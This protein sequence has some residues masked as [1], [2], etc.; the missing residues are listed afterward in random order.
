M[1]GLGE[2]GGRIGNRMEHL[3]GR[4]SA[5]VQATACATFVDEWVRAG[6]RHAVV[7]PGSRS[8]PLALALAADDRVTLEVFHDERSAAFAALG[9]GLATGV[10][11]VLV[12]TSGTAATHLHAAVVEADLSA[13]PML[14][15]TADR[16][17][18]L[19][20][21]GAPQ[22]IDQTHLYGRSVRWF[23]DPG[24]PEA[25]T[26]ATWR[27]VAAR[28]VVEATGA[29][30]GPVQ[31]NLPFR[32]PLVGV[33]AELP[34]G[35][36]GGAPWHRRVAARSLARLGD[37]LVTGLDAPR[38]VVVA[39][40]GCGDPAAVAALAEATGWPVIA[41]PRA[42]LDDSAEHVVA[43]ADAILRHAGFAADHRPDVVV[44]LG[45]PPAS[46]VLAQ[47]LAAS[48]AHQVLVSA[49]GAWHDPDRTAAVVL[50]ADPTEV[51]VQL[52]A[53]LR[54]A[55]GTP[56][57]A[58]WARAEAVA[59][60]AIAV[61]LE[62]SA[63]P[64]AALTEP[65]VA[66]RVV[67][68]VPAGGH[69]VVASSMPVR[70]VEWFGSRRPGR[71]VHANR[72]ANGIDGVVATGIGVALA[73]AAPTVVLVGDVAFAHDQS[74][75]TAL[76]RRGLALVVVVVD[77]GGGGIFSF[78]AQH[79]LVATDRFEQLFGTPHGTDVTTLAHA[80][81]LVVVT[82]DDPAALAGALDAAL[83]LAGRG[84]QAVVVHLTTVGRDANVAAHRRITDAV[85]AALGT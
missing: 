9:V 2:H 73:T 48:G 53:R 7:A 17:A 51:C 63:A 34:R 69:L 4:P 49:T 56:W 6:V 60:Q 45:E 33:C 5:D 83:D 70:D 16:P 29:R 12:C 82:C 36:P 44:R 1:E 75:L 54:G 62:A 59:R 26:A 27:S 32:E 50:D 55:T 41:D 10:P 22:T 23:C 14:V 78:L 13:V 77:N 80:H 18:E 20:D 30:P 31:L 19:R 52:A 21:V 72:G 40:R 66:R 42:G 64:G 85:V 24:V 37:D 28:A 84:P 61:A 47:W 57:A 39:G 76:A 67:E 11:A 71:R 25:A 74:S 15:C 58:R 68:A 3:A 81:G 46:K 8:T 38:G 79:D 35:R 65:V 43:C